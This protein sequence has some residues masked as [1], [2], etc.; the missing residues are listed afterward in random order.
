MEE[1]N[2]AEQLNINIVKKPQG[3]PKQIPNTQEEKTKER[4]NNN[5]A[6]ANLEN[7]L[8]KLQKAE[9]QYNEALQQLN[10]QVKPTP[11]P[12]AKPK[13]KTK[14]EDVITEDN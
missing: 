4:P 9:T 12:K 13:R 14:K 6:I 5:K 11:K 10:N 3:R 1:T 7:K 8:T 2:T